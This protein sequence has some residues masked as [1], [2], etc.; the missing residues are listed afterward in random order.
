VEIILLNNLYTQTHFFNAEWEKQ[1]QDYR[2]T[3]YTGI[4]ES[5]YGL[6][7]RFNVGLDAF[8]KAVR[9]RSVPLQTLTFEQ[10]R[11][12]HHA[13]TGIAPK[14]KVAP[15][16]SLQ[17]LTIETGVFIPLAQDPEAAH[18]NRAGCLLANR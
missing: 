7:G 13:F 10:N 12:A 8:Y 14:V 18:H 3:Y 4:L 1:K 5:S 16:A 9:I 17:N 6:S 15:L 11:N 2:S